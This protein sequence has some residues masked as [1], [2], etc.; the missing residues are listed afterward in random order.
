MI[1]VY[2]AKIDENKHSRYLKKY[3]KC[4][5]K[6][7]NSKVHSYKRWQ[8]A[9]LS[10]LGR[11]L[12]FSYISNNNISNVSVNSIIYNEFGKP[13]LPGNPFYFNVTHSRDLVVCCFNINQEI[14]VDIEYKKAMDVYE[15]KT[16]MLEIEWKRIIQKKDYLDE[17]Y[18]YW[19]EKESVIKAAG[20]GFQIPL[21]SFTI[22]GG[23]SKINGDSFQT[24]RFEIDENYCCN[25]SLKIKELIFPEIQIDEIFI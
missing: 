24:L 19:T 5:D 16:Q 8:D 4:F 18:Q 3:L 12:I 7:F 15:F 23:F 13:Y 25:L 1:Q 14:G 2:Y 10:L 6:D 11:V 9:Q 17:F 20:K 22:K 21:K